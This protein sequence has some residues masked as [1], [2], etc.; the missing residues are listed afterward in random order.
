MRKREEI[1]EDKL[2]EVIVLF[3][4]AGIKNEQIKDAFKEKLNVFFVEETKWL[5][6]ES[7]VNVVRNFSQNERR[8]FFEKVKCYI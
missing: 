8:E 3:L 1:D 7:I 6:V 2:V 5:T 4:A